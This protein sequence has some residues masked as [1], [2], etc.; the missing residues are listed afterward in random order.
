M[1]ALRKT[2]ENGL[3]NRKDECF[4]LS[5]TSCDPRQ[6][7]VDPTVKLA[8]LFGTATTQA[9]HEYILTEQGKLWQLWVDIS[10]L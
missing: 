5:S 10:L 7:L 6:N 1:N 9:T 3:V 4:L 8:T 2:H